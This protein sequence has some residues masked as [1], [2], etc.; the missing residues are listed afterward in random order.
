VAENSAETRRRGPGKPFKKGESPNPGGRPKLLPEFR[1]K[2]RAV[3][4]ES[5]I[6]RWTTEVVGT[7]ENGWTPGPDWLRA[8]ELLAAYGYG[9]PT[10]AVEHTGEGGEALSIQIVRKVAS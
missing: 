7:E 9:R 3:V 6:Q 1:A 2:C 5:V 8:S 4:D 10:Q